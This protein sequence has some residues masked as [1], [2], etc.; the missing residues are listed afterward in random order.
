MAEGPTLKLTEPLESAPTSPARHTRLSPGLRVPSARPARPTPLDDRGDVG[1]RPMSPDEDESLV[2]KGKQRAVD[3][4]DEEEEEEE[5]EDDPNA[6]A[7]I[8]EVSLS[9]PRP[10]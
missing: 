4:E 3:V 10:S 2:A 5:E 8:Q 9:L 7:R 6:E 1:L